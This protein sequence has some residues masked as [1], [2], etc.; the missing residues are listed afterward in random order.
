MNSGPEEIV[1]AD[2]EGEV[3]IVEH[4]GVKWGQGDSVRWDPGYGSGIYVPYSEAEARADH[5][6]TPGSRL[7][8][9]TETTLVVTTPWK[10][11]E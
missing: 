8:K 1:N 5:A 11:T 3:K 7:V 9:R 10:E 6:R 2:G 4:W